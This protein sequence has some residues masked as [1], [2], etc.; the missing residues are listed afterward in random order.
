MWDLLLFNALGERFFEGRHIRRRILLT[1]TQTMYLTD[2]LLCA[3]M[4]GAK[5]AAEEMRPER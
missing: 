5:I 4:E 1:A 3:Y 2:A